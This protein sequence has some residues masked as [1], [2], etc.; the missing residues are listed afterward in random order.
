MNPIVGE[1]VIG[2]GGQNLTA[3]ELTVLVMLADGATPSAI[4]TAVNG[5]RAAVRQ[6]E[7]NLRAKLGA[8]TKT[9]TIARGFVLD[10]LAP[11]ALCLLLSVLSV[12]AFPDGQT[13]RVP[14]RAGAPTTASRAS[15]TQRQDVGPGGPLPNIAALYA[16]VS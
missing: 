16:Q 3:E 7:R 15:R 11:R 9:H 6:I 12:G 8:K 14:R 2:Q 5:D 10:V 1:D 13:N 4:E